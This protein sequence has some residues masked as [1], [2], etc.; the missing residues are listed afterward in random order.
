MDKIISANW[1]RFLDDCQTPIGKNNVKT[2]EFSDT[3]NCI[4]ETIQLTM[5]FSNMGT[6][7]FKYFDKTR[8]QWDMDEFILGTYWYAVMSSMLHKS[9]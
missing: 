5:K 2:R 3:L 9:S 7:F 8:Q 6:S 1:S 4:K